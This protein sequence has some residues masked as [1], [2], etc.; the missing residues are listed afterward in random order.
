MLLLPMGLGYAVAAR[1]DG[2]AVWISAALLL[3]F[4]ARAAAVPT[5]ARHRE[6]RPLPRGLLARR[7]AWAVL[8]GLAATACVALAFRSTPAGRSTLAEAL[9]PPVV[10]G[11]IHAALGLYS[12]DR[13]LWGELVGMAGL[14]SAAPLVAVAAGAPFD[15]RAGG[16]AA[17][18]FAYFLSSL[19]FVRAYR[20]LKSAGRIDAR[21]CLWA[22]AG[23]VAA[24]GVLWAAGCLPAAALAAF[25]PVLAR[26]V[27]GLAHPPRDLAALGWRE[28]SVAV[29]FTLA[30]SAAF[31]CF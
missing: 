18:A 24:L 15:R 19:A 20:K 31:I 9:L 30:G 5:L 25:A 22:H 1:F 2:V 28:I 12:R 26:T 23:I 4:L 27:W 6:G 17:L 7:L 13:G 11:L 8:Y 3:F 10:L 16:A 21:L 14:A 29:A